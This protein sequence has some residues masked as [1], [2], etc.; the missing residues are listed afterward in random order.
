MKRRDFLKYASLS[1]LS[2]ALGACSMTSSPA[3]NRKPNIIYILADDLGY[4][5][6]SCYGQTKFKTPNIDALAAGGIRFT[7]HYS[8]NTVCAPS[9]CSLMTGLHSGH[10]QIRGNKEIQPVGQH[11]IDADT[12]TV[13][14]MLKTEGY[15]TGMF[16][17]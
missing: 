9:R 13:G 15:T 16:G 7:Q 1:S 3:A 12:Y 5:D 14:K 8:G 2:L 6:L 11:P 4:G 17:K 10:G